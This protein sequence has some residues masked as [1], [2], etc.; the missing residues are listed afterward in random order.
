MLVAVKSKEKPAVLCASDTKWARGKAPRV[1]QYKKRVRFSNLPNAFET[2]P[3]QVH[4]PSCVKPMRPDTNKDNAFT[5]AAGSLSMLLGERIWL[6][7]QL[8][9]TSS[10]YIYNQ[11]SGCCHIKGSLTEIM[12]PPKPW[13]ASAHSITALSWGYPTP[14]F[15]RVVQTE[16]EEGGGQAS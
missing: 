7:F 2:S 5:S 10:P 1:N 6:G 11:L 12:W 9:Q 14:V 15:L 3:G 16:P 13:A 8:F 4:P